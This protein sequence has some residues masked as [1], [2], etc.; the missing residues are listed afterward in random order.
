[1]NATQIMSFTHVDRLG[2]NGTGCSL[3]ATCCSTM[4]TLLV[5]LNKD[6]DSLTTSQAKQIV[7][8]VKS[9]LLLSDTVRF[10]TICNNLSRLREEIQLSVVPMYFNKSERMKG[11]VSTPSLFKSFQSWI[12]LFLTVAHSR[13]EHP[14]M[15]LT[16]AVLVR[17]YFQQPSTSQ[18]LECKAHK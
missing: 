5:D 10:K 1:M 2:S 18:L 3:N 14:K 8:D 4:S 16:L 12:W 11:K 7:I 17:T 15:C 13:T 9:D 6:C